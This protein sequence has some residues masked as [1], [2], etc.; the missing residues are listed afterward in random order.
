MPQGPDRLRD[1]FLRDGNDG[2][3]ECEEIIKK[4]GGEIH[5]GL[6]SGLPETNWAEELD[7]AVTYLVYEWD[8]AYI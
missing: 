4:H 2:I 3:H 6:I 5:R 8:Y 1:K 7:D